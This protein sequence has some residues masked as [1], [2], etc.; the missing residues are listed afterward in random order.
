MALFKNGDIID[1][2]IP[3]QSINVRLSD[4]EIS[5]RLAAKLPFEAKIKHGWLARYTY[6]VT[7]ADT[8]A[9]LRVPNN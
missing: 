9:I 1:I 8:G 7:S 6:F 3:K 2:D 4:E 5:R